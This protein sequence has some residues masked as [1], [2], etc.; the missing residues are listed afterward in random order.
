VKQCEERYN[1]MKSNQRR[2]YNNRYNESNIFSAEFITADCTRELLKQKYKDQ[3]IQIDLVSIQ[4]SFHYCFES[5]SQAKC[6]IRNASE[7]LKTGGIFIG[8]TPDSQEIIRRLRESGSNVFG[9]DVYSVKF[10][11][12]FVDQNY[13]IPLFGAKYDFHL[14]GVVD[15]PEFLVYF[16]VF[17]EI[18]N[19]YGLKL[20]FRKTFGQIFQEN[21]HNRD[22]KQLLNIM[23]ALERYSTHSETTLVGD[24]DKDYKHVKE[25]VDSFP[26]QSDAR[27]IG[28][29]SQSEW[30]AISIYIAF[31]FEKVSDS[32]INESSNKR[33]KT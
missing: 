27:N 29:L 21:K 24:P 2:N 13:K 16:P 30:D 32:G 3:N 11:Q 28:T 26:N 8:T 7:S 9:N 25:F 5:L 1:E 6:M 12:Q 22:Y 20:I 31:A 33:L 10:D 14:E 18:C 15:C 17:E 19:K 4:F 23:D